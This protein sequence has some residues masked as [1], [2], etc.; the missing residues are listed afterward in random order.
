MNISAIVSWFLV[1]AN[2]EDTVFIVKKC[3]Y[4][5]KV[6]QTYHRALE[7]MVFYW[8]NFWKLVL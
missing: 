6:Q 7:Y 3:V 2:T 4:E 1:F 5:G 8:R